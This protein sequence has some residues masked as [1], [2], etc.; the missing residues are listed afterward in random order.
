MQRSVENVVD[1][2]VIRFG[3]VGHLR[4]RGGHAPL[5]GLR[6]ILSALA[7]ALAQ[8]LARR[9]EDEDGAGARQQALDLGGALPVDLQNHIAVGGQLLGDKA[10]R[11]AVQVAEHFRMLQEFVAT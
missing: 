10:P 9:R 11:R 5:D 6:I 7:Q 8:C 4:H 2:Q 1:H 3:V